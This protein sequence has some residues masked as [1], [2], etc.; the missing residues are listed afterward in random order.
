MADN[1]SEQKYRKIIIQ[2]I[3]LSRYLPPEKY[4]TLFDVHKFHYHLFFFNVPYFKF[5]QF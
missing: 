2:S 1:I 3:M 4:I 5:S